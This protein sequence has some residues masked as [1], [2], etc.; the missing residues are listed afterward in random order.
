LRGEVG[1]G[2]YKA[3]AIR[4]DRSEKAFKE[5]LTKVNSL[6][7]VQ[8]D[9]CTPQARLSEVRGRNKCERELPENSKAH[10]QN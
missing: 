5:L 2:K 3:R 7:L 10:S 1:K 9:A 8:G 4:V 6:A